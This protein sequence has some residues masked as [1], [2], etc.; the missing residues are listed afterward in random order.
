MQ[1]RPKR[2]GQKKQDTALLS[3]P[4]D[5]VRPT[6]PISRRQK[7]RRLPVTRNGPRFPHRVAAERRSPDGHV[8]PPRPRMNE[9]AEVVVRDA[10]EKS[11]SPDYMRPTTTL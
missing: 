3:P 11:R 6:S 10:S 7:D 8:P 1:N 5:P 9:D 2:K 4:H